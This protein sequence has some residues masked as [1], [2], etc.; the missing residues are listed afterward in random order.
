ML[1]RQGGCHG[2]S[3]GPL[4]CKEVGKWFLRGVVSWGDERCRV[5]FYSVF[6]RVSNYLDWI[7]SKLGG[8]L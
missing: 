3:G 4:V 5:G 6:A 7:N 2:D 1:S 8:N